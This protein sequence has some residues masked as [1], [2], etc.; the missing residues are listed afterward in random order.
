MST[1]LAVVTGAFGASTDV[2]GVPV[3]HFNLLDA[4]GGSVLL[5]RDAAAPTYCPWVKLQLKV[6]GDRTHPSAIFEI[7]RVIATAVAPEISL[8]QAL[9]YFMRNLATERL[10]DTLQ[11]WQACYPPTAEKLTSAAQL[12]L[13]VPP[14]MPRSAALR[15]RALHEG[16]VRL[17]SNLWLNVDAKTRR[18]DEA[19]LCFFSDDV[20]SMLHAKD[21]WRVYQFFFGDEQ[22]NFWQ[23]FCWPFLVHAILDTLKIRPLSSQLFHVDTMHFLDKRRRHR[24]TT[25]HPCPSLDQAKA[26]WRASPVGVHTKQVVATIAEHARLRVFHSTDFF[27]LSD[28]LPE[29]G[30]APY[31]IIPNRIDVES[32]K[33]PHFAIPSVGDG[34]LDHFCC[35]NTDYCAVEQCSEW[36]R[37]TASQIWL[38]DTRRDHLFPQHAQ[39]LR[40][41]VLPQD[42]THT[43][44][45]TDSTTR[46]ATLSSSTA[47]PWY[48][49]TSRWNAA[50]DG[51]AAPL[52][53]GP[54]QVTSVVLEHAA[55]TTLVEVVRWLQKYADLADGSG[56]RFYVVGC[57][58]EF[59]CT[60]LRRSGNFFRDLLS[61]RAPALPFVV[62]RH[63]VLLAH[64]VHVLLMLRSKL[65]RNF[66]AFTVPAFDECNSR[67]VL[68]LFAQQIHVLK[69]SSAAATRAVDYQILFLDHAHADVFSA[70]CQCHGFPP[71]QQDT[72]H[73][74]WLRCRAPVRIR[75][76]GDVGKVDS[77][78]TT[79]VGSTRPENIKKRAVDCR[80]A[81]VT[82][83]FHRDKRLK[84]NATNLAPVKI[85]CS[86]GDK[87]QPLTVQTLAL[88]DGDMHD[89]TFLEV[90]ADD[91]SL[92]LRALMVAIARTRLRLIFFGK[93]PRRTLSERLCKSIE[94]AG[95]LDCMKGVP[96]NH[97]QTLA[98]LDVL[99]KLRAVQMTNHIERCSLFARVFAHAFHLHCR[100]KEVQQI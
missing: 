66:P 92:D 29:F 32:A 7:C 47:L 69:S 21:R 58:L 75:S 54:S 38:F 33:T 43:L 15:I 68:E 62:T 27:P 24:Y 35:L 50:E 88:D 67:K 25:I 9:Q 56:V 97:K 86:R 78:A 94:R 49:L 40:Q 37:H 42:T 30:Q 39:Y 95:L 4:A 11:T 90:P 89:Y 23:L 46:S 52:K 93:D 17:M 41:H 48:A 80:G 5:R 82:V 3:C 53:L 16:F 31:G 34:P 100:D 79:V 28:A 14:K 6:Q 57:S 76:T 81:Q 36:L 26:S 44:L 84:T 65:T 59:G 99:E 1:S 60:Y 19:L 64:E 71:Q 85:D 51:T 20:L 70:W 77:V 12:C 61:V 10:P 73:N 13:K 63:H 55:K 8:R 72:A 96:R 74:T 98:R 22:Q 18:A 45:L 83:E 2:R 87:V 91:D